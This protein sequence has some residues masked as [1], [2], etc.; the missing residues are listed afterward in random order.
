[1]SHIA[2]FDAISLFSGAMGLDL[3]LESIGRLIDDDLDPVGARFRIR[4]CV[5]SD[6]TMRATIRTNLGRAKLNHG[7]RIYGDIRHIRNPKS[8]LED[9]GIEGELPLIC[10]GPPCQSFSTAGRRGTV[11]DARGSLI[12]E[13]VRFVKEMRPKFFL[14]E[15]VRGLFSAAI[16]HRPIRERGSGN[17]P[18]ADEEQSG[19]VLRLLLRD[20]EEIKYHVDAFEVNAVNYGAPQLR[21]RVLLIGNKYNI[22]L[23]FPPPTYGPHG[24]LLKPWRTLGDAI[25]DLN[26]E[27][28]VL[29]DF[30]P[31]KK[32]YLSMVPSGGNWRSLPVDIQKESMGKAWY[33][34]GGRSGWWRHLSFDLPCPCL[35]TMPNHSGTALCHPTN[36]RVLSIREYARI[37]E[38]PDDWK[39]WGTPAEQYLQLGNAV[40]VRLGEVVGK[41][42][43]D[44]LLSLGE[45]TEIRPEESVL[46][47]CRVYV[48]SHVRT[49]KWY[50]EG[51]AVVRDLA[52]A[53]SS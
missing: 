30:S 40:P 33:A 8:I 9:C 48:K 6:P 47:S 46:P 36:L 50:A 29:M 15:N 42:I 31:R 32:R 20:F 37:Q 21:E 7:F 53:R 27:R 39:V 41:V 28:P 45:K 51:K 25:G 13:F 23:K 44:A 1:M 49:R 17:P 3:G 19:S 34:K 12:W 18:L 10:G 52:L 35:V 22:G 11:Q 5:E 26:E 43:G 16:R 24:I 2:T 38:F 14:M 4:A